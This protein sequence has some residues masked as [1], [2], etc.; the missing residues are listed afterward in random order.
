MDH[1]AYACGLGRV[2]A[3]F[4]ALELCIRMFLCELNNQ[5]ILLSKRKR[6]K[7]PRLDPKSVLFNDYGIT[8]PR[9]P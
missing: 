2:I 8:R 1:D 7:E 4:H 6:P 5:G 9:H 3:N